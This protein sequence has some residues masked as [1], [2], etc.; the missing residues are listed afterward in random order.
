[1]S[2]EKYKL[3]Q[4]GNDGHF[5]QQST[6]DSKLYICPNCYAKD[7]IEIPIQQEGVRPADPAIQ[8]NQYK[9]YTCNVC[10]VSFTT[11]PGSRYYR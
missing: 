6:A 10:N 4:L 8:A 11:H 1:M 9:L 2:D 5:V 7:K 3:V